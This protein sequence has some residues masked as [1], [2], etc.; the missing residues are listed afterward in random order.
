[1]R[2]AAGRDEVVVVGCRE[3]QVAVTDPSLDIP[4]T[5]RPPT[6]KSANLPPDSNLGS[7]NDSSTVITFSAQTISSRVPGFVP[8]A[9]GTRARPNSVPAASASA[10][11]SASSAPSRAAAG[12]K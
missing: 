1:V 6:L 7:T 11:A 9:P 10:S 4:D 12:R 5:G 2:D 8:R 3:L